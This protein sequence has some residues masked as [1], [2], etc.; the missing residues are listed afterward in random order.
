MYLKKKIIIVFYGFNTIING[1]FKFLLSSFS[2]SIFERKMEILK[3]LELGI[4]NNWDEGIKYW[5]KKK[6]LLLNC[7]IKEAR[8]EE[9]MSILFKNIYLHLFLCGVDSQK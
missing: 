4:G 1:I 5:V 6:N 3:V 7:E 9:K 2:L 8:W